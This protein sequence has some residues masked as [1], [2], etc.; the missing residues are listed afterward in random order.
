MGTPN[1]KWLVDKPV[2]VKQW[3]LTSEKLQTLEQLVQEQ[4]NDQHT[5]E[6]TSP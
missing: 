3:H 2:W 6:L 1:F 4:L 5:E